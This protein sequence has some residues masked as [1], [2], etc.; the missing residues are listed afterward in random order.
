MNFYF[1]ADIFRGKKAGIYRY[2]H[3]MAVR[4]LAD[5]EVDCHFLSGSGL[6]KKKFV[7]AFSEVFDGRVSLYESY[8]LGN[9]MCVGRAARDLYDG[10]R[11]SYKQ[12]PSIKNKLKREYYRLRSSAENRRLNRLGAS[13][14]LSGRN[15]IVFSPHNALSDG[16]F[17]LKSPAF[18]VQV[19]YDLI[20]VL[21]RTYFDDTSV[22]DRVYENLNRVDLIV[23]ISDSTRADLVKLR[24]DLDPGKIVSIPLA[25][26]E[27]FVPEVDAAKIQKVKKKYGIP[28][29]ADYVFSVSTVEPRKNQLRLVEAWTKIKSSVNMRNPKLVIAGGKGWGKDYLDRL[30]NHDQVDKTVIFTG[31]VD[32]EDLPVLYSGSILTAYPS[33]YEGFGIPVLESM[34]CGRFCV[35]SNVSSIPEIVGPDYPT[36]NPESVSEIAELLLSAI[37]DGEFR[38]R[39]EQLGFDRAKLF[40]WDKVY[41]ETKAAVQASASNYF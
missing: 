17:A 19:V 35:T 2:S 18:K 8:V 12:D 36:V 33:L 24:P 39:M 32:D 30:A 16:F 21:F 28:I 41:R 13:F 37:N 38:E 4:F 29:D 5:P 6:T 40:T 11:E 10:A 14:H 31:Y 22:F 23:T 15:P 1:D 9:G 26:S 27:H 34:G 7:K 25:A 3:E 20:P